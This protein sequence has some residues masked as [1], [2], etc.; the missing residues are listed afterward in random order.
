MRFSSMP[1][2][3]ERIAR[4]L[5]ATRPIP[6]PL[7]DTPPRA[8]AIYRPFFKAGIA[9]TLSLGA[10]WGAYL[11]VRIALTGSFTAAGLHEVNAHGHAQ[12]FGWVGLFVMGFAYQAFPRF[13]HTSLAWVGAARASFV[14]MVLGIVGRSVSEPLAESVAALAP[15]AVA[16]SV[17]E[18]IAIGLFVAV[19]LRTWRGSGQRLAVYDYYILSALVWFVV[20]AVYEA[21]YLATTLTAADAGQL[22]NLVATWQGALRDVQIHGFALLMILGVSQRM[23]PHFYGLPTPNRTI[24]WAALATL[25]AAVIGEAT[26]L[27]LMR[28][29]GHGWA[30]LWYASVL[31]LAGSIAVLV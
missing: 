7:A 26:G 18:V 21:A 12:I 10:V 31:L 1:D 11:L 13:K 28:A 29:V 27:I 8:D 3:I 5:Q 15:V 17:V 30:A 14:L 4:P 16:S 20:Q 24:G 23:F 6:L 19:I 9:V 2:T 22:V 25:D